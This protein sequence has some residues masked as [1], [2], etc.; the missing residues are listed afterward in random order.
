MATHRKW[1]GLLPTTGRELKLHHGAK[2]QI[3]ARHNGRESP[4]IQ[5]PSCNLV[6]TCPIIA[7]SRRSSGHV[8][9]SFEGSFQTHLVQRLPTLFAGYDFKQASTLHGPHQLGWFLHQIMPGERQKRSFPILAQNSMS[10]QEQTEQIQRNQRS[11]KHIKAHLL[12]TRA[13]DEADPHLNDH[14]GVWD[15]KRNEP[16]NASR[17]GCIRIPK[18][19][20]IV[21]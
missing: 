17:Y 7:L 1:P 11:S 4:I 18:Y 16:R 8:C 12:Q 15:M 2:S 5:A 20:Q 6:E 3:T 21:S 13:M 14:W 10:A 19:P 9:T